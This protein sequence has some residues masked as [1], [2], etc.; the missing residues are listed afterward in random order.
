MSQPTA[1]TTLRHRLITSLLVI[2]SLAAFHLPMNGEAVD[3]LYHIYLNAMPADKAAAADV[4]FGKLHDAQV[5]DEVLHYSEQGKPDQAD[6]RL[7]YLMSEYYFNQEHFEKS[8]EASRRAKD[9]LDQVSDLTLK[10][11]VFNTC[12]R[13]FPPGVI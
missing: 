12:Q 1:I 5:C 9:L 4:V 10:S 11:D 13:L 7:H 2:V 6:A 8:L 3:S